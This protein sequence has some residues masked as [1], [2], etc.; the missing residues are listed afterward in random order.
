MNRRQYTFGKE[1][2]Y[3]KFQSKNSYIN[4]NINNN[5]NILNNNSS[6]KN[7]DINY[8]NINKNNKNFYNGKEKQKLNNDLL[9][10]I[11]NAEKIKEKEN[12]QPIS[13]KKIEPI[14]KPPSNNLMRKVL[15]L[16]SKFC[17]Y[18]FRSIVIACN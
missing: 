18:S 4:I 6:L 1:E 11:L 10:N 13:P 9:E 14:K 16:F 5:N 12:I 15:C 7:M 8:N 2:D 17:N 3:Y